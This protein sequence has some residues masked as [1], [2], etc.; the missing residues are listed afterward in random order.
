MVLYGCGL[1]GLV[2]NGYPSLNPL[3]Y[4]TFELKQRNSLIQ[5][6]MRRYV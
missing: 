6:I 1:R 2:E 5:R 3:T 4:L